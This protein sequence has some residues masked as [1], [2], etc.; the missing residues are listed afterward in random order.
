M[1]LPAPAPTV[2]PTPTPKLFALTWPLLLELLLG[3]AVGIAGTAL[4]ARLSDAHAGAFAL[5]HQVFGALFLLFRIVGAGVGVVLTQALGAGR[6]DAADEVARAVLG[7][8]TW[9]GL[10]VALPA[11][12]A[13]RP[14]LQLLNAPA[15][16]LPLAVPF[17]I[18]LAPAMLL[19][20]WNASMTAVMRA[21]LR[22][23][24]TLAVMVAMQLAHLLLMGPLIFGWGLIP[25]LGLPG[26]ALAVIVAR[27]LAIALHL[28]LWRDRLGL[29][30]TWADAWRLRRPQLAAVARIGLPGAAENIAYRL[31]FMVSVAV[32][33]GFG[34]AAL[35]THAY[36][37]QV[38]MIVLLFGLATGLSVEVLVGH[39]IGAGRLHQA[40]ALVRRALGRGLLVSMAVATLAAL[41]AG[42]SLRLFTQDAAIIHSASVLLWWTVL[43]EPG[44]TFNLV[45]I[46]ALRA[47]GDARFP[48][49][50]GALSMLVVLAGGSWLLGQV[51]GLGLVGVWIA[52]IADE[53]IRGL[54]MWRRWATLAWVPHARA[55]HRRLRPAGARGI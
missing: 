45:V 49:M 31:S 20:A 11:L 43:L 29:R 35:A 28:W 46:N 36:A 33:G 5:T 14:L 41:S 34:A 53:W 55:S 27:A 32:V 15:E 22:A 42:W 50:A 9:I 54:I 25:A 2:S 21:H 30:P 13:A 51:L 8:S 38:I 39:L 19:D 48:V 16:V 44:R 18:A 26:Y 40:H 47:A 17:L 3:M 10:A 23:R 52:Y 24:D 7:A 4:A 6:R 37:Q 1:S 12:F